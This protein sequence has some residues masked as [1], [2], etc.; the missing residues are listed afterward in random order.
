MR[1]HADI[2]ASES[3]SPIGKIAWVYNNSNCYLFIGNRMADGSPGLPLGRACSRY[4][5]L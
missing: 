4:D 1:R 3:S 5:A 2:T